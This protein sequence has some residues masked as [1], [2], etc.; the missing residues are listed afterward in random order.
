MASGLLSQLFLARR[1]GPWW[2]A[3]RPRERTLAREQHGARTRGLLWEMQDR[4]APAVVMTKTE[5]RISVRGRGVG[6]TLMIPAEKGS[7]GPRLLPRG[8]IETRSN[9]RMAGRKLN[10]P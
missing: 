7:A 2:A 8:H 9:C 3:A 5:G 4:S 6:I 10:V 1:S